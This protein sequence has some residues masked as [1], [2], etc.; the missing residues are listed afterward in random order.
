MIVNIYDVGHG[1]T[2]YVRDE[3]TGANS[4]ID[5]G[6]NEETGFHPVD[7]IL[8]EH[9]VIGGLIVQNYDEDHINGIPHLIERAGPTPVSA[10]Y[11]NP[12]TNLQLLGL[13]WPP[14]KSMWTLM[15]LRNQY[16]GPLP[17]A[18]PGG[19]VY[20]SHSLEPLSGLHRHEQSKFGHLRA[21]PR[22][23]AGFPGRFGKSGLARF[24]EERIF[25]RRVG[26]RERVRG[27]APWARERILRGRVRLLQAGHR[28][29]LG[30]ADAGR[31]AGK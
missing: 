7:E 20:I 11:G 6:F 14:S 15:G 28:H 1:F 16:S 8:D 24:V 27:R 13:K 5:C 31:H 17:A 3:I 19:E 25:P 23:L 22:I 18:R 2:A 30:R 10:L 21:E 9:G 12:I 29:H 4:L 26:A